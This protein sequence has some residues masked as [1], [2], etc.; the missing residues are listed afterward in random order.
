MAT[1]WSTPAELVGQIE[2]LWNHG[3][4]L[5][6]EGL[7]AFPR[8]LKM[9]RPM[10]RE[11]GDRF[12]EVRQ[13]IRELED[14]ARTY[15]YVLEMEPVAH[16][17]L[18]L[19]P[20]PAR[21]VVRS[22]DDA[23]RMIGKTR[24]A[25]RFHALAASIGE[26]FAALAS[27]TVERPLKVVEVGDEWPRVLAVLRWFA[28]H[29]ACGLYRRQLEIEG[30]DTKF[31]EVH[32]GLIT[33]L[34][35]R[36]LPP[37]HVGPRGA[38]FD[39]RFGLREKPPVIRFR[40]LDPSQSLA[41]LCDLTVPVADFA[42]LA[43]PSEDVIVTENE[44]NLLALPTTPNALALFGQ[45][46]GLERLG[47]V[48]WLRCRRVH[49][50]GDIDT[51]GFAMLDRFRAHFPETRSLLMDLQTLLAHPRMWVTEKEPSTDVLAR[52]TPDES[53]LVREL[54][55]GTHGERIRLEQ[56]RVSFA[57]VRAALVAIQH[58]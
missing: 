39:C 44:V 47:D 51:H 26:A 11:V 6:T 37:E 8:A 21:V 25:E 27:W 34:L 53:Q 3:E 32:Q 15:G 46:Y 19:N 1:A 58:C 56:E 28:D 48:P 16:R 17:Q 30:V 43:L 57:A 41:G 14:G 35:E 9:R 4:L 54:R 29:P 12:H 10:P 33:E 45:G 13:W 49:Y 40:L 18:G 20:L 42:R 55:R 38:S 24:T 23:L 31:I 50:W 36:V 22:A 5:R 2:R 7:A 52:L